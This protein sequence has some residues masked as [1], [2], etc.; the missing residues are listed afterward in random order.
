VTETPADPRHPDPDSLDVTIDFNDIYPG[1]G[2]RA[3][4]TIVF[5]GPVSPGIYEF[6]INLDV[7]T[8]T[9]GTTP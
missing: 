8:F 2:C 1:S 3:R 6:V 9:S 5:I 7:K 4:G